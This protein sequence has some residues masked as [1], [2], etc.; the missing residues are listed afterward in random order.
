MA[1]LV[2]IRRWNNSETATKLSSCGSTT[3]LVT[4]KDDD[5]GEPGLIKRLYGI[6]LTYLVN[7]TTAKT[8]AVSYALDGATA[9]TTAQ[10]PIGNLD[11]SASGWQT[12]DILISVIQS[13]SSAKFSITMGW[14]AGV[15]A[16]NDISVEFRPVYKRVT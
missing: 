15:Y 9:L 6:R 4:F 12:D 14:E 7:G 10:I 2:N 3:G 11:A 8:S 1:D 5:L 16:I 13:C